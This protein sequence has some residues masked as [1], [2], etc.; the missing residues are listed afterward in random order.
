MDLEGGALLRSFQEV[1][2]ATGIISEK[3]GWATTTKYAFTTFLST[4]RGLNAATSILPPTTDKIAN[5][6]WTEAQTIRTVTEAEV[7]DYQACCHRQMIR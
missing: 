1:G 3:E 7:F 5:L 6:L 2:I 4:D